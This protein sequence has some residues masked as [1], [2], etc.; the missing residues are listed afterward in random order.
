MSGEGDSQPARPRLPHA[1]QVQQVQQV[2]QAQPR[3]RVAVLNRM[4]TTTGG[5]A[6]NYSIRIV[7]QLAARHEMHVFA[8]EIAHDWPGVTYHRVPLPFRRP[9]WLNQLW[10]ALYTAWHTRQGFDAVHSHENTWQGSVQTIHVQPVR[11]SLLAGRSGWRLALRWLKIVTSP[12]LLTYVLLEAARFRGQPGRRHVVLTSTSLQAEALAA[13]PKAG[14]LMS[15]ITPGVQMPQPGWSKTEARRALGLPARMQQEGQ[16]TLLLFVA[17]DYARKG[18]GELLQAL[19]RLPE[20]V[21]LAVVGNPAH[22]AA[23]AQQA[24]ALGVDPRVHFVGALRDVAPAYR[25]ADMLVHPTHADTYAMVV[26]EAMAHGLPVVVSGPAH[27]GISTEL[28]DGEDAVLLRDPHDVA[29][30]TV[31]LRRVLGDEALRGR[32][33]V[34]AAAFARG[35]DWGTA[36]GGYE[37]LYRP[38]N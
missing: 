29:E 31:A 33:A 30:L 22:I 24:A 20:D 11:Y 7:E 16:G 13:Y 18:L 4:F 9:R 10:F 26:L 32:L 36:A 15:V 1:Q 23:H 37:G 17:N 35:H 38:P 8:Q 27:C 34:N 21:T 5:G 3:L 19:A 25:A 12:R 28:R 2:Q 14:P 6:E